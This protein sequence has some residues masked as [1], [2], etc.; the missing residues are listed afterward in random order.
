MNPATPDVNEVREQVEDNR[1]Q[2]EIDAFNAV[3]QR[4]QNQNGTI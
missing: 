2:Q 3:Q 4:L 1:T